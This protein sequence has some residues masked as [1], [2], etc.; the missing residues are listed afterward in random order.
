MAQTTLEASKRRENLAGAFSLAHPELV[1]NRN[2]MLLDDVI[3]TGST[4]EEIRGVLLQAGA[5]QVLAV[6]LAH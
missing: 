5:K 6:A 4:V 3:T 1:A 2:I